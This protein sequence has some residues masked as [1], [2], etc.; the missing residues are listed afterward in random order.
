MSQRAVALS[1][2]GDGS[3]PPST[4]YG[5]PLTVVDGRVRLAGRV[6]RGIGDVV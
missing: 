1:S 5:V 2:L 4:E 6:E 3:E